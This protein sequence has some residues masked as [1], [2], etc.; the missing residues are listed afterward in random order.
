MLKQFLFPTFFFFYFFSTGCTTSKN[1]NNKNSY[2]NQ[3]YVNPTQVQ[4]DW[5]NLY[6]KNHSTQVKSF[7]TYSKETKM[8]LSEREIPYAWNGIA[9]NWNSKYLNS[10]NKYDFM[11]HHGVDCTRFLW[12]LYAEKMRLPFNAKIKSAPIL[13][14]SFAQS[15]IN[16]ELGNFVPLK[17]EGSLFKPRTGDILAFPGHALAVLDP[18][19]CIAIQSASWVCKKITNSGSCLH[20]A[21]GK[22]A[23]VSIYKLMNR[24]DCHDGAWKQLDSPRNKFTAGWRHKA[25]NTWIEKIPSKAEINETITLIG[26]NISNRFIYFSG[27]KHPSKTSHSQSKMNSINDYKLDIVSLK[28]PHD[29]KTGKLKIYWDN[30]IKPNI[31]HTVES[32]DVLYIENNKYLSSR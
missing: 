8:E 18:N 26:Y 20:S 14:H 27:A 5:K 31:R 15:K 19:K 32:N 10:K 23:G 1:L 25:L 28:I 11:R 17:K 2:Q 30:K 12:H 7:L 22:D 29:A 13:S 24:G 21:K 9:Q 4:V 3:N 6:S 16:K